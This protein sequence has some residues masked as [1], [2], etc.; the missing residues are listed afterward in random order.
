[1]M[2]AGSSATQESKAPAE[3][4][5]RGETEPLSGVDICFN[6]VR[7]TGQGGDFVVVWSD[8]GGGPK[9][10]AARRKIL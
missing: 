5:D 6:G 7:E 3:A 1:M 10:L 2:T 9:L 4:G 8:R